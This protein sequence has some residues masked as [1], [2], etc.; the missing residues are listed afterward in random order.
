[1]T[2]TV[3][4]QRGWP[5]RAGFA[6][7]ALV[8]VLSLALIAGQ[9]GP[10][11]DRR[12]AA[13]SIRIVG[14]PVLQ[15]RRGDTETRRFGALTY[16]GGIEL[17]AADPQFGG[18][19]AIHTGPDGQTFL[20]LTDTGDWLRGRLTVDREGAPTGVENA[21]I[22]P[23]RLASGR[24]AKDV[25]LW[26]AES[27]AVSDGKAYV[28]IERDHTLLA[29]DLGADGTPGPGQPIPL[30]Q[31]VAEWRE[32]RGIEGLGVFPV[33]TPLAGRLIGLSERS[34]A[35]DEPTDGFVMSVDG[36]DSFPI[37]L[38]RREGFD[39]TAIDALPN[40]DIAVLERRFS[41]RRGVAMRLRRIKAADVTP[42]ALL[43][44][45]TVLEADNAYHIDNMEGL[46]LHRDTAGSL[47]VTLL[48]D[49]NFSIAQRTLILR[50]RW[51]GE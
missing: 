34:G 33:G 35:A 24:R 50:F 17:R 42:G 21:S 8:G 14:Y 6:A 40:G 44:G 27:L 4:P 38:A 48:S 32:N 5:K 19:S 51:E 29:F 12:M 47:I 15:F 36:R 49:N 10:A 7:V 26:D 3:A 31:G 23:L 18:L 9:G 25:G 37:R 43:D 20:A 30:P 2:A 22:G 11:I 16:L 41:P 46:S 1:M 28:G 13:E 45:E 39:L